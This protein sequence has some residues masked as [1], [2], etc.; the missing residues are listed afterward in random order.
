M[1]IIYFIIA[2]GILVLVHEW[3]H[4]IVARKSGIRV[5]QFSIGF[6]PKIFSFKGPETEYKVSLLPLGGYVKLFGEDPVAEAE[7]NK[8]LEKQIASSQDAFS[9]KPVSKRLATVLAGPI[10]NLVLCFIL[11]PIVFMVGRTVPAILEETPVVLGVKADSPALTAGIIKGDKI[12]KINDE[13]VSHWSDVLNWIILHPDDKGV[14]EIDREGSIHK[15]AL[16]TTHSPFTDQEMGYTGFEP[17]F[18]WGDD[19][20]VGSVSPK[21]PADKMGLKEK[22]LIVAINGTPVKSWTEMTHL[23]RESKGNLVNI[24]FKRGEEVLTAEAKP[25]YHEGSQVYIIGITRYSDPNSMVKKS[26]GFVESFQKGMHETGK[27]FG[28]TADVLGRLFT[29]KL[30][31]KALGGPVQIAQATGAAARSG[32]GE[33]LYFLAFLSMQLGILNLLPI[34]VLDGGHVVFMAIEGVMRKPLSLKIRNSLTQVGL[35]LLLTLM[36]VITFNDV[37]RIWG[38]ADMWQSLKG[39]F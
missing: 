8:E 19:P 33:F 14:F 29:F 38:F 39:L 21:S 32:F 9:S 15:I 24:Q 20:I 26:Y 6:G 22:D 25:E 13:K 4:F 23:I 12:L 37:D 7:G 35:V 11:M 16:Q 17:Q 1:T 5:E 2:L 3:G 36:V 30:S 31:Y 10:M 27:L 28:L 18:F 34:P